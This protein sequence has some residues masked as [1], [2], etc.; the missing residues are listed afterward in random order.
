[1]P[2]AALLLAVLGFAL[3]A[4]AS[5]GRNDRGDPTAAAAQT[6]VCAHGCAFTSIQGAITAA[7]PGDTITIGPG[8]YVE[9]LV[10]DRPLTLQGLEDG[11]VLYP[12]DLRPAVLERRWLALRRRLEHDPRPVRAT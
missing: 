11:T 6:T 8:R 3:P 4:A 5:A 12:A 7:S 1:M 2:R 10:V 9:N